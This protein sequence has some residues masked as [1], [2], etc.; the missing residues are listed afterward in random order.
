M[1]LVAYLVLVCVLLGLGTLVASILPTG[2]ARIGLGAV[3]FLA[4]VVDATWFFAPMGG[5][6]AALGDAAWVGAF[7]LA[8]LLAPFALV[9][10][11]TPVIVLTSGMTASA[12][13]IF[14]MAMRVLPH[15]TVI[16]EPTSGEHS[17]MLGRMLPNGWE[18]TLS[19]EEYVLAGGEVFERAGVPPEVAVELDPVALAN[20]QD[21]MLNMA[22][23]Y[24]LTH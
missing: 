17:D 22:L 10:L 5:W 2:G 9:A 7:G 1:T 3:L 12:A 18:F 19:N 11:A 23:T 4:V 14:V 13:E 20:G 6:S 21:V 15:V 8:G 16:G 24:L